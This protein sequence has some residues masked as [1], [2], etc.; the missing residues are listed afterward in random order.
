MEKIRRA[1]QD[2]FTI[3]TAALQRVEGQ[4]AVARY[5]TA[6]PLEG[7]WSIVAIGKAAQ[8]MAKGAQAV[9][10]DRIS[11]GLVISKTGH[12]DKNWLTAS[13]FIGLES[14]H[15][16]PDQSS[17]DA[18]A[19]LLQFIE[20]QPDEARLLFLISGGTSSLVEVLPKGV[21]LE[22][23]QALNEWMLSSGLSIE[24]MNRLR[25]AVSLIK[26]GGLLSYLGS[27]TVKGLLISD[28]P[29]DDPAVIGSGLLLAD[30][31]PIPLDSFDLPS[32]VEDMIQSAPQSPLSAHAAELAVVANLSV[33]RDAAEQKA[34]ELGYQVQMSHAFIG[35]NVETVAER[36]ALEVSDSLPGVY[37]WGGEPSMMLPD[38]PGRGGRN[39]HLALAAAIA[40]DGR[41]DVCFLAA[42]TDGT[43]GPGDDAGG[44]IDGGTIT[45][46]RRA[47]LDAITCLKG[48]DSG[49]FLEASEDLINTGPTGT[50][51]MDLMIGMKLR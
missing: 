49:T 24:R 5:L 40:L 21:G 41:D 25:K 6:N 16:V 43:D 2:L 31:A 4:T 1:R 22:E 28:V 47:G 18:G 48:A 46:G 50:N 30:A 27:R 45:R 19:Q 35:A 7:D 29:T 33:A 11:G 12:L 38:Q 34:R 17:L 14:S 20:S 3:F 51:V 44:L 8:A 23:L 15:P 39:Q 26:G 9:L 10:G 36:M 42:G 32:W 37:I 13:P